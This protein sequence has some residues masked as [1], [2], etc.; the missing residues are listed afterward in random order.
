MMMS[1]TINKTVKIDAF[2]D[3]VVKQVEEGTEHLDAMYLSAAILSGEIARLASLAIDK[4]QEA[5]HDRTE[6]FQQENLDECAL[7]SIGSC[8][9]V[10]HL[11]VQRNKCPHHKKKQYSMHSTSY[12]N[13]RNHKIL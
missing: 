13:M 9:M 3:D 8:G 2:L 7:A 4:Y 1:N 5:T 10:K 11:T 12:S 6:L